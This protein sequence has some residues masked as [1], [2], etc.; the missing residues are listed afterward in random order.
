MPPSPAREP[1]QLAHREPATG[2]A[3]AGQPSGQPRFLTQLELHADRFEQ[4]A[5]ELAEALSS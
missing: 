2:P 1:G 3:E 4:A 5:R